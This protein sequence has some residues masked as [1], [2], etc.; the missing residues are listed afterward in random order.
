MSE[1]GTSA[2]V[3]TTPQ[4]DETAQFQEDAAAEPDHPVSTDTTESNQEEHKETPE[5]KTTEPENTIDSNQPDHSDKTNGIDPALLQ[6]YE[7]KSKIPDNKKKRWENSDVKVLSHSKKVDDVYYEIELTNQTTRE[8]TFVF[9]GHKE[10]QWLYR[11]CDQKT[12]IGGHVLHP[13][14]TL[15][16]TVSPQLL[17]L[18]LECHAVYGDI[19]KKACRS[20]ESFLCFLVHSDFFGTL[21]EVHSFFCNDEV[22]SHEPLSDGGLLS[23]ISRA[24]SN[25]QCSQLSDP[26]KEFAEALDRVDQKIPKFQS[27]CESCELN[28]S[29]QQ[30]VALSMVDVL[31]A[32]DVVSSFE[33]DHGSKESS[34]CLGRLR[35]GLEYYKQ[36]TYDVSVDELSTVSFNFDLYHHYHRQ[37][38][39]MLLR[40][41]KSMQHL[42][43]CRTQLEKATK[44]QKKEA[45]DAAH[46]LADTEYE[47]ITAAAK[48]EL[49]AFQSHYVLSMKQALI[50]CCEASI[51]HHSKTV[52]CLASIV[53][54]M[55]N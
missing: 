17:E 50:D 37:Y 41:L 24:Y 20:I 54:E 2:A 15:P 13:F 40:R 39:S 18:N 6:S 29:S 16:Y 51:S 3:E 36:C 25:Y 53:D 52:K 55:K 33:A 26:E 30:G 31:M 1:E 10:I 14:P 4:E 38:K 9:R 28:I 47:E 45:A 42:Q 23:N 46:K 22:P 12:N 43:N 27:T 34:Q 49:T 8:T 11:F 21:P 7:P 35:D 32:L 48:E 5:D 44:P 19:N